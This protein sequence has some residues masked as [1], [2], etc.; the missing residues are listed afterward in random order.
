MKMLREMAEEEKQAEAKKAQIRE[1]PWIG[2]LRVECG[3]LELD[4]SFV[5]SCKLPAAPRDTRYA[6]FVVL[7]QGATVFVVT[8]VE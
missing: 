5:S 2:A 6:P 8:E 4:G 1:R 3:L 7:P